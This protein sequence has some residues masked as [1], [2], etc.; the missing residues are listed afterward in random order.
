MFFNAVLLFTTL[1]T[2]HN[3]PLFINVKEH[4]LPHLTAHDYSFK[5]KAS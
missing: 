4:L 3:N 5:T 1:T 2:D